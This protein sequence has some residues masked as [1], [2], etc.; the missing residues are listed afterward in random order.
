[1][2]RLLGRA[3]KRRAHGAVGPVTG[4][5]SS[6][7]YFARGYRFARRLPA[8]TGGGSAAAS[9]PPGPIGE[10]FEAHTAGPG[11]MKWGHY[12][13]IYDRHLGR[14]RGRGA[15]LVEVGVLGGGNLAMWR[16]FLGPDSHV[17]GIDIDPDCRE[18]ARDGVE[19]FIG[20]QGDPSFWRHFLEGEPEFDI[21]IDDGGHLA[22]QQ[23]LT[24]QYLLPSLRPGG[25]YICEDIHGARQPF[26]SFVD[27]LTR[28]LHDI[29]RVFDANPASA[30][31]QHVASVHRYPLLTVIEKPATRVEAFRMRA[32][33]T[34][35]P[36]RAAPRAPSPSAARTD[37]RADRGPSPTAA[38]ARR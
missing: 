3:P 29:G 7:R 33:G 18:L 1:M 16:S 31:H 37:S 14:F 26:H 13:P 30:L 4:T 34:Q 17:Y 5:I 11:I 15:G 10:Y 6:A 12:F 22:P 25:V 36:E 35:W 2:N 21:V 38:P 9:E 8:P 20:D 32:K 27:G 24:L 28:P 23:A 19:I